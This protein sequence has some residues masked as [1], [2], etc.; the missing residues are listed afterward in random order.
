[1]DGEQ[2]RNNRKGNFVGFVLLMTLMLVVTYCDIER[3]L[4]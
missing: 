4:S 1:M 2:G 3:L